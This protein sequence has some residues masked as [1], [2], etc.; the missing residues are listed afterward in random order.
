[1]AEHTRRELLQLG[2]MLA[3]AVGLNQTLG[4][5]GGKPADTPPETPPPTPPAAGA[6]T[7]PATATQ[8][9][10]TT[11]NPPS[12]LRKPEQAETLKAL[13]RRQE[14]RTPIKPL[15]EAAQS[16]GQRQ[17]LDPEGNSLLL[18]GTFLVERP[19][20][21]LREEGRSLF[22]CRVEGSKATRT[23]EIHENQLLELMEREAEAGFSEFIVSGEVTRYR[24]RNYL[25]LR[26][27][28]RRVG[29]GNVKP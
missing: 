10:P 26:K 18:E 6:E 21:L 4:Q 16:D 22:I 15:Q 20:R 13:L 28:L 8:P 2:A 19:G 29:H 23:M 24:G 25:L 5:E 11:S 7:Q 12:S 9:A 1:M 27:I 3:A 17:G 14:G